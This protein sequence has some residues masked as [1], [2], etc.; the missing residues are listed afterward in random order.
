M[1]IGNASLPGLCSTDRGS[2]RQRPPRKRLPP[3]HSR[4]WEAI[5]CSPMSHTRG[6][7]GVRGTLPNGDIFQLSRPV[8][9]TWVD[10]IVG[11]GLSH[12]SNWSDLTRFSSPLRAWRE[13]PVKQGVLRTWDTMPLA[14]AF[15]RFPPS[16]F[17]DVFASLSHSIDTCVTKIAFSAGYR[18]VARHCSRWWPHS[19]IVHQSLQ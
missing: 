19:S 17:K 3:A 9:G 10:S 6:A 15:L 12:G 1:L 5:L 11:R 18:D 4:K 8:S 2:H 13:R 16:Y 7:S 14:L